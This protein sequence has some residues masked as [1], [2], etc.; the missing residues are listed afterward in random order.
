ME[1]EADKAEQESLELKMAEYGEKHIGDEYIG[2]IIAFKP[3]GLD[4]KLSNNLRGTVREEDINIPD[5]KE[6][7]KIKRG[8]RVYVVIKE[9]SI[10][11]RAIYFEI[12]GTEKTKAKQL[13]K[14]DL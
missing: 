2:Q 14:E 7:R 3:Y 10:P 8:Q 4:I 5:I 13:I 6:K 12:T 9:V 11:V 1:R